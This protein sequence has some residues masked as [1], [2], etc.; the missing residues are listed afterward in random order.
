MTYWL[1][2]GGFFCTNKLPIQTFPTCTFLNKGANN[3][4]KV[5]GSTSCCQDAIVCFVWELSISSGGQCKNSFFFDLIYQQEY[6]EKL[7]KVG[8]TFFYS[9]EFHSDSFE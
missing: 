8:N 7:S 2:H 3:R 6:I 9:N 4:E 1:I 5:Y